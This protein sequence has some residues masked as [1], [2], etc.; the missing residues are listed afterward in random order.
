MQ[1]MEWGLEAHGFR[2][3]NLGY[4]SRRGTV[5]ELADR[6]LP[7]AIAACGAAPRIHFVTHS[8]GGILLRHWAA[9]NE[10]PRAGRAVLLGAP[11]LGS[12]IVD[13]LGHLRAFR[14]LNGPAGIELGTGPASVPAALPRAVPFEVGLVAGTRSLNPALSAMVAGRDDGKVSV[15]SALGMEA[16]DRIAVPVTHT[17]L[18]S[19]PRVVELAADFLETGSFRGGAEGRP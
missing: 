3:V 12:E 11:N 17:W 4:P 1:V 6:A 5:A 2:V 16:A 14:T 9:R 10:I 13:R 15:A 7:A 8:M 19:H 18:A